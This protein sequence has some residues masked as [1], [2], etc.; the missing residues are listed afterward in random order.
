MECLE[1][2]VE[3]IHGEK[4]KGREGRKKQTEKSKV[5]V[6]N[7]KKKVKDGAEE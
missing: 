6:G 3:E 4:E 2:G 7:E 1:D 5:N